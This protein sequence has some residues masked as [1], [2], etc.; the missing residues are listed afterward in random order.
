M[1]DNEHTWCAGLPVMQSRDLTPSE[2]HEIRL[3]RRSAIIKAWISLLG[4]LVVLISFVAVTD[5][6]SQSEGSSTA[7]GA[8]VFVILGLFLGVPLCITIANDYFR[9]ANALKQQCSDSEVL[10]C[11]GM[12]ADIVAQPGELKKILR[13]AGDSSK[14][15]LEV[16]A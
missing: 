4:I 3:S 8:F 15:V 13:Q 6:L 11:E 1:P 2:T 14:V 16:L 12:I 9:R 10:V 5:I 7:A